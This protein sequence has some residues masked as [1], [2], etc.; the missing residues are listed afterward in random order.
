[1]SLLGR[2]LGVGALAALWL[3]DLKAW[4]LVVAVG[5]TFLWVKVVQIRLRQLARF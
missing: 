4:W 1:M 5:V 2:L 3:S